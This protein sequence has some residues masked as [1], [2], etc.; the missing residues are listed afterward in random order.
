[1]NE[2]KWL[3]KEGSKWMEKG[4]IER[5]QLEG[6]LSLYEKKNKNL[7]PILGSI[8][9]GLGVLTFVA[10][11][12]SNMSDVFRLTIICGALIG[13][14]LIG[15]HLV[16]KG[17]R[18]LGTALI[19]IGI[20]IFG[21]GIFLTAQMFHIVSYNAAAFIFWMLVALLFYMML[22]NKYFYLLSLV[23]GTAGLLYSA[24]SFQVFSFSLAF[25][26]VVAAGYV[27]FKEDHPLFYYFYS[28]TYTITGI[29]FLVAYDLTYIWMTV[30]FLLLYGISEWT[31]SEKGQL[32]FKNISILGSLAVI[33]VHVFFLGELIHY[34]ED[35]L[36]N[37]LLYFIILI[38]IGA[39]IGWNKIRRNIQSN[40]V[41]F[42]LFLPLFLFGDIGDVLY[43]LLAF[44]Y[45]LFILIQGYQLEE[46]DRINR[47]TFLFLISTLVAYIQLAWNFLPK[48]MF[49]LAGG[50]LLFILSWLLERRRRKWVHKT[51]GGQS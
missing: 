13:F 12:W 42:A 10:S 18:T 51:K 36:S 29:T 41:D 17:S 24:L 49:F 50:I 15:F 11:N 32:A 39:L 27:T 21:A 31:R 47:G 7:L 14:Q 16:E 8:L 28:I 45:S 6:I 25:L 37:D 22:P 40:W 46:S 23:I 48:S 2:R 20:I 4:M 43:L 9:I 19:G 26:V 3:E 34:E 30:I 35:I 44:G 5:E 38:G 1:M 33:F